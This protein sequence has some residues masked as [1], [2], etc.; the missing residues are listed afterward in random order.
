MKKKLPVPPYWLML[1]GPAFVWAAT[2]QGSGELIWWPYLV[3]RYGKAFLFLLL[4][5][6]LIQFFVN[7]EIAKYT[8]ITG[9]GIWRGF[10]T[11]A[12]WYYL[13]LFLL[14]FINFLWLGGYA[15]AGGS[16]IYEIVKVPGNIK[17]GSLFW[18]YVLIAVFSFGLIV[19]KTV[20]KFIETIMEVVTAVTILGLIISAFLVV[21]IPDLVDFIGALFNPTNLGKGVDWQGFDY[22]QLITG[23]VFAGM[24]GFLN[25]MYSYWMKDKGVGMASYSQKISGLITKDTQVVEDVPLVFEDDSENRLNFKKWKQY[26][27]VDAG[28][29]VLI[30]A[31]T[32]ILTSLLAFVLL[33]PNR[34]YP[35]GWSITVA[36]SAFFEASFGLFG[37]ILFLLVAGA[38]LIDTWLSLSDGVARQFADF[39]FNY[40]PRARKKPMKF[41]YY[42]WLFFIIGTTVVTMPLATP[43]FFFKAVGVISVFAFVFYIPGLWY[44]NYVKLPKIYPAFVRGRKSEEA[45]LIMV[46]LVYTFL[47][48]WYI[49]MIW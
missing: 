22:S 30:N 44:L 26:L 9:K 19:S 13:P 46:W 18:A 41:W 7:K 43:S 6:A 21:K 10:L 48:V 38:F 49:V 39:T 12:R 1:L 2:A 28:L 27:N 37:R 23:I 16:S 32:I 33:W 20:Y 45:A 40:S 11:L 14:C 42:L 5:A 3:A 36:Q 35:Q 17:F 31:L 4:P 34:N 24:G 25:L 47:A 8:L 29:A 15:S